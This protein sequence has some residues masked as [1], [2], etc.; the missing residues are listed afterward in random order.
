VNYDDATEYAKWLNTQER[1]AGRLPSGYRY[2]L[3]SK[4][5]WTAFAQCG[6]NRKFPW[7]D[8]MPPKYGNYQGQEGVAEFSKILV[9][10]DGF[11]VT[12]PVENSGKMNGICLESAKRLGMHSQIESDLAFDAWRGAS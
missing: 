11:P 1:K 5:E 4:N 7:G 3:P 12:C 2:R 9:Y 10:N 8:S 6:V